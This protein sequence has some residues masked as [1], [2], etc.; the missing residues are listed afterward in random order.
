L[1][2]LD[3]TTNQQV[4]EGRPATDH[5]RMRRPIVH[6][7]LVNLIVA[8]M[9]R[10]AIYCWY[11]P[12]GVTHYVDDPA[13]V[14]VEYRDQIVTFVNDLPPPPPAPVEEAPP[15]PTPA[16][17]P[18]PVTVQEQPQRIDS[19]FDEGYWAGV[20]AARLSAPPA[21]LGPIVQNVQIFEAPPQ[22]PSYVVVGPAFIPR[23]IPP[24]PRRFPPG[25]GGRFLRGPAGPSPVG[26]AGPPPIS[27]GRP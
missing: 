26:A 7:V 4:D 2:T 13:K 12:Q 27:G 3:G 14:P 24:P 5:A 17:A 1:P 23:A 25:G 10:A 9:A 6:A 11:D 18:A 22:A 16:A 15:P 8:A 20:A 19:G 21:P